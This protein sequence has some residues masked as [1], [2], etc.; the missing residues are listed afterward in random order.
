MRVAAVNV[1]LRSGGK[2][3]AAVVADPFSH[4][5]FWT[6]GRAAFVRADGQDTPLAPTGHSQL[7]DLNCDPPFPNAPAF[8]AVT[9]GADAAFAARFRR[10]WSRPRWRS[11]GSPRVSEQPISRTVTCAQ[12]CT[13]ARPRPLRSGWLHGHRPARS[14]VGERGHMAGG[15]GGCRDPC[16]SR[17]SGAEVPG[18]RACGQG[19][20]QSWSRPPLGSFRSQHATFRALVAR[21]VCLR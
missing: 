6:D 15:G 14:D 4:E 7:V 3:L 1:A 2:C 17:V 8:R 18:L 12:A 20:G 5:M 16:R 9:L 21:V 11:P 10:G 19:P 13:S